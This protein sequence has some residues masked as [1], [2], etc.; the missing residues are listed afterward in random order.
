MKK[1]WILLA[2]SLLLAFIIHSRD[3]KLRAWGKE[4]A[5]DHLVTFL[6]I[7]LLGTFCG[8]RIWYNDTVTY[9]QMYQQAPALAEFWDSEDANFADGLGFGY[10]LSLLK[11]LG[12]SS[13]DYLMFFA[14][15]TVIP[16]VWFVHKYCD[17]FVFGVFLMFATGFYTFSFA[18]IKQCVALG[19]CLIATDAAIHRKWIR[20]LLFVALACLF[21]PYAIVYLIVPLMTFKPWTFRTFLYIFL[22]VATGF[23]LDNLIGT[24]VDITALIGGNYDMSEFIGEGV[25]VFRV[26]VAFV[27]FAITA[28][29]HRD[30]FSDSER[31]ENMIFNLAMINALIM[32]VGLFGTANYFARLANYFLPMQVVTLPWIINKLR[33]RTGLPLKWPCVIGYTGYFIYENAILKSFDVCIA[34]TSLWGYLS[35]HL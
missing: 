35:S 2:F 19:I 10:I 7:V 12:F 18:A 1:L 22:F 16:Y 11:E 13:Q 28:L 30:L 27:P 4:S 32:F 17:D 31:D 23:L 15:V 14:F 24:I 25:N 33:Y 20:Y 5:H 26:L 34:H 9:L 29:F 6:L 21:H 3:R 8:L